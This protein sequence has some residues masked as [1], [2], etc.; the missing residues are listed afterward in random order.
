LARRE[1]KANRLGYRIFRWLLAETVSFSYKVRAENLELL[2][3]FKPPYVLLANHNNFWD[4]FFLTSIITDRVYFVT[5]DMHFHNPVRGWFLRIVGAIPKTKFV[6]DLETIKNIMRAKQDGGIIG[7]FPEGRRSWDG[8]SLPLLYSTAKLVKLLKIPVVVPLLK[9][10]YLSRPR[11][12]TSKRRGRV[13]VSFKMGFSGEEVRSLSVDQIFERMSGLLRYNEW[14]FQRR[15]MIPFQGRRRAESL[16]LTLFMCP[17]CRSLGRLRSRKHR[18][19]CRS[20]GYSVHVNTYGFLEKE[21]EKLYFE[22]IRDWNLWQLAEL[23]KLLS[24][25]KAEGSAEEVFKDRQVWLYRGERKKPLKKRHFG[26]LGLYIDRLEF[27][28]LKGEQIRFP[29][30]E[31]SGINVQDQERLEF[32]HGDSTYRFTFAGERVSAYKWLNALF[33]LKNQEAV[34]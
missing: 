9:G 11:W 14:D 8:H 20:C 34:A 23:G 33:M 21:S 22:N 17:H 15:H 4:P 6:S 28:T 26:S 30:E 2:R 24:A 31:L 13:F 3:T 10:A 18:F 7:I 29:L 27:G 5:S 25:K 19:F 12:T 1:V 16:E 32:Y